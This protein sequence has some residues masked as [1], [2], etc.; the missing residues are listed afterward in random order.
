MVTLSLLVL[1]H[2]SI[3]GSVFRFSPA[4]S[5]Q[6]LCSVFLHCWLA[7]IF[8]PRKN[9]LFLPPNE[10]TPLNHWKLRVFVISTSYLT[11]LKRMAWVLQ[12]TNAMDISSVLLVQKKDTLLNVFMESIRCNFHEWANLLCSHSWEMK[13]IFSICR[14]S[15]TQSIFSWSVQSNANLLFHLSK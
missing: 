4:K 14:L 10:M 9:Q 11:N 5:I 12:W 8:P 2:I 7:V 3:S 6:F 1:L 13:T 15:S